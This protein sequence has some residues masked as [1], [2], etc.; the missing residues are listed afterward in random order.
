VSCGVDQPST[1]DPRR[2]EPGVTD[3]DLRFGRS[4][5]SQ[6]LLVPSSPP[7]QSLR[8]AP[9]PLPRVNLLAVD[10]GHLSLTKTVEKGLP[11]MLR[12]HVEFFNDDDDSPRRRRRE[13]REEVRR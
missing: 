5:Q 1:Q 4:H 9:R 2:G 13:K 11:G 8:S 6:P 7:D 3:F 12:E 10:V